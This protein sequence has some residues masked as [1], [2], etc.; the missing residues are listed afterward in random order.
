MKSEIPLTPEQRMFAADHHELVYNFLRESGL[1]EDEY[2]DIVIFGYL[3]AVSRYFKEP[4]LRRYTFATVAWKAMQGALANHQR[5]AG[6]KRRCLEMVSI[7]LELPEGEEQNLVSKSGDSRELMA[8][9]E[10]D[11]ILHDLARLVSRRQMDMVRMK[12]DG[13]G[14]RDIAHR[15][16]ATMKE[17]NTLLDEAHRVL[18]ELCYE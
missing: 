5:T 8:Q 18:R 10:A 3:K 6:R 15:Q 13:Y 14:I 11:L 12:S 9:L 1:P 17:V 7:R 2:Y 16:N 4:D